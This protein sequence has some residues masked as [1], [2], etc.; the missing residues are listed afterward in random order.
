MLKLATSLALGTEA[1]ALPGGIVADQLVVE[2][3]AP[4][5]VVIQYR[6]AACTAP[7]APLSAAIKQSCRIVRKVVDEPHDARGPS[8][9]EIMSLALVCSG[10]ANRGDA[11]VARPPQE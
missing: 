8:S 7:V 1:P 4:P 5:A 10:R 2:P 3:N 6:F 9:K 11:L